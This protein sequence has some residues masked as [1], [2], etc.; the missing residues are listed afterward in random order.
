MNDN[1]GRSVYFFKWPR[2]TQGR[3]GVGM[4]RQEK[5]ASSGSMVH[6]KA[7]SGAVEGVIGIFDIRGAPQ[8]KNIA[9][10]LG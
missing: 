2:P 3:T 9:V 7:F 8:T 5:N 1:A 6:I 4:E 10:V